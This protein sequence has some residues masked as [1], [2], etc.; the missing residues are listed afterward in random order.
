MA[1]VR[2]RRMAA[3]TKETQIEWEFGP[4]WKGQV[5]REGPE[6][7]RLVEGW[8]VTV[9]DKGLVEKRVLGDAVVVAAALEGWMKV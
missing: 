6:T 1:V 5:E 8:V 3:S 7:V 9:V 4:D 2:R